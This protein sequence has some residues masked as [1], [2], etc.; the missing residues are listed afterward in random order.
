MNQTEKSLQ[1]LYIA[2]MGRS[3][4]TL[5]GNTLGSIPGF[6]HLGEMRFILDMGVLENR[7]C[8]CGR[9]FEDC[10]FWDAAMR[11][12][13]LAIDRDKA[14]H[15]IE[16]REDYS[17]SIH[18]PLFLIRPFREWL[19]RCLDVYIDF[20]RGVY[21]AAASQSGAKVLID[22]SKFP[23]YG[24]LLQLI[25]E[26]DVKVV[27]LVR[28][29]RAVAFSWSKTKT[30][31]DPDE[32]LYFRKYGTMGSTIRWSARNLASLWVNTNKASD[33]VIVRYEDFIQNP[34]NELT[35]IIE[36]IG[37]GTSKLPVS[38]AKTLIIEQSHSIWGNS[39]RLIHGP[40]PLKMDDLYQREQK[41]LDKLIATMFSLPLLGKYDYPVW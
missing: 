31:P 17:R 35:R 26:F 13:P 37:M 32:E 1:I 38:D 33:H 20:L 40:V 12:V 39:S 29:P 11:L 19:M 27:H 15:L 22:S 34:A 16:I 36:M 25:P 14:Q 7:L 18:L 41:I 3:G 6:F 4:S 28:D 9:Q 30:Q 10:D 2:G 8:A 23:T 5:L 21:R 24:Y